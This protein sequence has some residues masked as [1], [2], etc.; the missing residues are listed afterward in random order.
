M[1]ILTPMLTTDAWLLCQNVSPKASK[2]RILLDFFQ[3][4]EKKRVEGTD[5]RTA[6]D[7]L[8]RQLGPTDRTSLG[9]I[10]SILREAGYEV[11]YE[12]RYSAPVMPEPYASRLKGVL[13]FHDL[14]SAEQS[15]LH[16][17]GIY[18]DYSSA[19]DRVGMAMV[20]A[21]VKKGKLR[22]QSI[23]ANARVQAR[24]RQEKQ[25]IANWFRVWLETPDLFAVWLELR[26]S[27]D[28]FR[29]LFGVGDAAED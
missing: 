21:L 14:A 11:Q 19:A 2:K 1:F 17:D 25:E 15:L 6:H 12:D 16:L 20:F 24:K 3:T 13:E 18:R 4:R 7:E 22:A 8:R 28:E 29:L 26:K 10:A 9:Y 27:S 23:A 5:L